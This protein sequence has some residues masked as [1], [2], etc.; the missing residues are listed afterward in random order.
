MRWFG[1]SFSQTFYKKLAGMGEDADW[2]EG[3]K[4][5]KPGDE[6]DAFISYRGGSGKF[7]LFLTMCGMWHLQ[8]AFWLKKNFIKKKFGI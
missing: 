4:P 5:M 8:P 3:S 1:Y 7:F 2:H 6:Y